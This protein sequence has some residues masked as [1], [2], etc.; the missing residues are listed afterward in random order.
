MSGGSVAAGP[1]PVVTDQGN[2]RGVSNRPAP[3][4]IE[5]L[6]NPVLS[7][8][9]AQMMEQTAPMAEQIELSPEA[10]MAEATTR[11]GL[12]DFG[13]DGFRGPLEVLCRSLDTEAD[14][15]PMGRVS[16]FNQLSGFAANRL[17]IEQY[18][19]DHPDALEVPVNRPIVIAGLPRTG[20]T[21]LH[22]LISADPELRSLPW[23][24][25][26]EPVPPPEEAGTT[27]G[28]IERAKSGLAILNTAMPHYARMHEMT[29]D[30]VHEEIHL[31]GI[32]FS[33]MLF[34][35]MAVMP[36]WRSYYKEQDQT[37]HYEYLKRILQV[38]THQRP[39][40]E[41]WVLKSPQHLEQI[42]PLMNVFGDATVVFTHRD[43]VSITASF[44]T[45]I[46]YSARMSATHPVDVHGIGQWWAQL[47]EDMLRSCT[48]DRDL[49]APEQSMDVLFHEFM[50][51]DVAMVERIYDRAE[52]P[53]TPKVRAAMDAY[54]VDHPRDR[55]GRVIYDLTDFGID[56]AERRKSLNFYTNRFAVQPES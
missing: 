28:R 1:V 27:E 13:P 18:I 41:R 25:A 2:L 24:E 48:D 47:I 7:P 56:P 30:H 35:C 3:I 49:V 17:R 40:R 44:A 23:W 4:R 26:M 43:P 55:H 39:P 21:H 37:P 29:W 20:T 22:N 51:G 53:F 5:D 42:G 50:A 14:H 52:Q 46:C 11:T 36:S 31:L 15:S 32:D 8:E 54:M 19:K 33:T 38:L 34:D 9:I 16:S 45:M 12:S 6:V 10:V